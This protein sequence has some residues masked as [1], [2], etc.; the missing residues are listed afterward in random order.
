MYGLFTITILMSI[1]IQ[2]S[3]KYVMG[4]MNNNSII[5][6]DAL[7]T[8][9]AMIGVSLISGGKTQIEKD[10]SKLHGK[11]LL[12][13]LVSSICITI[14]TVIGFNLLRSEKLSYLVLVGTGIEIITLMV[15]SAMV[16]G[17]KITM[18]KILAIPFLLV[19]IYLAQ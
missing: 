7:I 6:I 4:F 19:G 18:H 1:T 8:G 10:L 2:I 13:L 11:T 9:I 5:F 12:V 3:R 15:V 14:S 17:E 16:L